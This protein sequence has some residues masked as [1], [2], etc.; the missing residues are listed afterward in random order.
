MT[1]LGNQNVLILLQ[2]NASTHTLKVC[3]CFGM[4]VIHCKKFFLNYLYFKVKINYY[5]FHKV[6][7]DL[8]HSELVFHFL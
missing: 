2:N 1:T 6:S 8:S 4:Y 3:A 7:A 5:L